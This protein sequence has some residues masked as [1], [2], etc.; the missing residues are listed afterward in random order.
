MQGCRFAGWGGPVACIYNKSEDMSCFAFGPKTCNL[1]TDVGHRPLRIGR[2]HALDVMGGGTSA[3]RCTPMG[4]GVS[5]QR[6]KLMSVR[7]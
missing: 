5:L 6:R 3:A 7:V 4:K 1:A 2:M